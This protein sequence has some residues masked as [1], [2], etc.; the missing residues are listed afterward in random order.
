M[1]PAMVIDVDIISRRARHVT[2]FHH[3]DRRD[4][5]GFGCNLFFC[6]KVARKGAGET[7]RSKVQCDLNPLSTEP[8]LH[9][10][11]VSGFGNGASG[12]FTELTNRTDSLTDSDLRRTVGAVIVNAT[13]ALLDRLADFR[14]PAVFSDLDDLR[15]DVDIR[16]ARQTCS[17]V[18]EVQWNRR[19]QSCRQL[20]RSLCRR[21]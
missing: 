11:S 18:E 4:L 3:S 21:E 7:S 12:V 15:D 1:P 20:C 13:C 10:A 8:H 19:R 17:A 14:Y 16:I 5:A 2:L 6:E 9:P